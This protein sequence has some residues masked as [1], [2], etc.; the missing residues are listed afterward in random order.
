MVA[1]VKKLREVFVLQT[2]CGENLSHFLKFI[3][4]RPESFRKTTGQNWKKGGF[5]FL[6]G[7]FCMGEGGIPDPP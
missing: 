5:E 4:V 2:R 6:D 3:F 7:R 1:P